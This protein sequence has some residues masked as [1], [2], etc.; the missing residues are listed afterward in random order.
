M[1]GG[2]GG[3]FGPAKGKS[4]VDEL[5]DQTFCFG[6]IKGEDTI[7]HYYVSDIVGTRKRTGALLL[8]PSFS[9]VSVSLRKRYEEMLPEGTG[10]IW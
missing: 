3:F 5:R 7:V 4:E 1:G 9:R 10:F 2:V 6:E 8:L